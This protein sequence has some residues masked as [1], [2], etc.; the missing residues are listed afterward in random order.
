MIKSS[1]AR[2]IGAKISKSNQSALQADGVTPLEILGETHLRLSH[3]KCTLLLDALVVSDLDVDILAGIPFMTVNDVSICPAKHQIIIQDDC[4]VTYGHV[5]SD[6]VQNRVRRTHAFVLRAE[7]Q[8][9]IVWPGSYIEVEV[10]KELQSDTVLTIESRFDKDKPKKAWVRPQITES[11]GGKLRIV[12]DTSD[13]Q[14]VG[15]HE[16]FCQAR[17]TS[18]ISD[19]DES[20]CESLTQNNTTRVLQTSVIHSDQVSV[21]PHKVLPAASRVEFRKLLQD[22]EQV[23]SPN[24]KGYNGAVGPLQASVNMGPVQPQQR[25]GRV[26]QYARDKLVELQSCFDELVFSRSQKTWASMLN[27]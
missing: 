26:L 1:V 19:S 7:S 24:F 17:Q 5:T 10:P 20:G 3:D 12:N 16:H 23:F 18:A 8:S 25:K 22:F 2:E 27:M 6:K 11:V 9:T 15:K 14:A 4:L 13:P 21:D